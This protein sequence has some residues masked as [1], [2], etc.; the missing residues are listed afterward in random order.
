MLASQKLCEDFGAKVLAN[1]AMLDLAYIKT[2]EKE[3]L[4]NLIVIERVLPLV[5]QFGSDSLDQH[6]W[7]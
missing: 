2:P 7:E 3:E 6:G 1:I 4:K 5:A